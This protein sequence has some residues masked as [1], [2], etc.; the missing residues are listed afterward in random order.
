MDNNAHNQERC[1]GAESNQE[2]VS[3]ESGVQISIQ[4]SVDIALASIKLR[5]LY[6]HSLTQTEVEYRCSITS[7]IATSLLRDEQPV[8]PLKK[9]PNEGVHH[10]V[11]TE[12]AAAY[13]KYQ[14]LT[15]LHQTFERWYAAHP[16]RRNTAIRKFSEL[17]S[18]LG[19]LHPDIACP[20]CG[21][22]D[23]YSG[24]DGVQCHSCPHEGGIGSHLGRIHKALAGWY[25]FSWDGR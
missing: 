13:R 1:N 19:A 17:V 23:I 24:P 6:R 12:Y 7:D 14:F 4:A 9:D 22:T 18:L 21:S 3:S 10:S 25:D 11:S 15:L 8:H 16:G 2:I 5:Y 20:E